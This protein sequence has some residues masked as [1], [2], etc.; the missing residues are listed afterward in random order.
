MRWLKLYKR[1][2]KSSSSSQSSSSPLPNVGRFKILNA[3]NLERTSWDLLRLLPLLLLLFL[4]PLRCPLQHWSGFARNFLILQF[5]LNCL[6]YNTTLSLSSPS[7]KPETEQQNASLYAAQ[8]WFAF[9]FSSFF[10][11][12]ARPAGSCHSSWP[13][14]RARAQ[15]L[16]FCIITCIKCTPCERQQLN[17]WSPLKKAHFAICLIH[18]SFKI[19]VC[20]CSHICSTAASS[21]SDWLAC[22]S[23]YQT[24][25]IT[26]WALRWCIE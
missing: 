12:L 24:I 18:R 13:H 21:G 3:K 15:Q 10:L 6:E 22:F 7:P 17:R 14:S 23:R 16:P 25:A 11:Q 9:L 5:L 2:E 4:L 20:V 1:R 26:R 8:S 19:A